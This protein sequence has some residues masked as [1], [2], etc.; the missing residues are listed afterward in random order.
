M[1][2]EELDQLAALVRR[3]LDGSAS[4]QVADERTDVTGFLHASGK[5]LLDAMLIE[6]VGSDDRYWFLFINW[7]KD[8]YYLVV[9]GAKKGRPLVELWRVEQGAGGRELVWTYTARKRDKEQENRERERRFGVLAGSREQRFVLPGQSDEV[10][11]F[12][13]NV[14]AVVRIRQLSEDLTSPIAEEQRR[15]EAVNNERMQSDA[16]DPAFQAQ[17]TI[18]YGP[19]G[20]GKTYATT[21]RCVEICDGHAPEG[22]EELRCQYG[23]LMDEGRIDFVTFHQSYGYEEFVEGLRPMASDAGGL[24][25]EVVAGVLKRVA[26]KARTDRARPHVLVVDE[27]NRANVSKVM[28]EL[29]TLLEEDKREGA[30]NEVAVTL[31]Y[32]GERF[33]LP[34]NL[35]I[36]G[37]MNTADRSI[38]L[39]DTAL[40]R[41]FRFE[42]MSPDPDLLVE[43]G[44]R[45]G[46]DLPEVLRVMNERL[47]YLVDRDHLIG[48]AWFMDAQSREDVDVTMRSKIIPLIAEYFYDDWSKVGA[49]LGGTG[50]FVEGRSL[51]RPP[52]LDTDLGEDRYRWTVRQAF[53]E[54]AYDRLVSR[55]APAEGGE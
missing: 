52:G 4:F 45:T 39:L 18:L 7:N 55:T 33:T 50:H 32:S 36:L 37:T 41:R 15:K 31:P 44:V 10:D 13:E 11:T 26:E 46:V 27:I 53:P 3:G 22:P 16:T 9:F 21:R 30:K 38:A 8:E 54:D 49:V 5:E 14:F 12:L 29:I 17:N 47:E 35:H 40:R 43:A 6:R 34:A 19:P 23:A 2:R 51:D 48:H 28:G 24:K 42:E 20:T 1:D 25:L